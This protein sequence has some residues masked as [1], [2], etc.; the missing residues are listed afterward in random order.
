MIYFPFKNG[1]NLGNWMWQYAAALSTGHEVTGWLQDPAAE[2]KLVPYGDIFGKL[3]MVRELP[4]YVEFFEQ[5]K[6]EP[7]KPLSFPADKKI[8]INGYYGREDFYDEALVRRRFAITPERENRLRNKYGR[9][10][11]APNVTG[12]SVRR[13]DYM[14]KQQWHPFV[15]ERYFFDCIAKI[16]ECN[17][18][19]VCSDDIPWCEKFFTAKK[20]KDKE[21]VFVKGE[22][23]LDQLYI[24]TLCK[25]NI[26][27][28]SS[29]S[30]WG[31]WLN[32]NVKKRV[33][34]P[35]LWFGFAF[36]YI[37]GPYFKNIEIVE[38]HYTLFSYVWAKITWA[39]L[40]F[41]RKFYFAY[42]PFKTILSRL[43]GGK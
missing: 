2:R 32:A 26:L 10:L 42:K 19:I 20:F 21:F 11:D 38:N 6:T 24:H 28:N 29:F 1:T 15:G 35:S 40:N 13:G 41:K 30:W 27:S 25:N 7:I 5:P 3:P 16:P 14:W 39:W 33:L 43:K 8:C 18:F 31:A 9:W 17:V 36:N 23:V 34:A 4:K 22:S 12:I 37:K